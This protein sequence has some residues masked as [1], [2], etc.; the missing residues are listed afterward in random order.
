[1]LQVVKNNYSASLLLPDKIVSNASACNDFQ[2]E[3]AFWLEM[4]FW[5]EMT[6]P[7]T[8]IWQEI[9]FRPKMAMSQNVTNQLHFG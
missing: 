1:M 6:L 3:M 5:A 2:L 4:T 7:E 9:V 8:I